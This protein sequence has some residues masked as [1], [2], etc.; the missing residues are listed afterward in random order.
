MKVC[1]GLQGSVDKASSELPM[2]QCCY[3][4]HSSSFAWKEHPGARIISNFIQSVIWL[5]SKGVAILQTNLWLACSLLGIEYIGKH[6]S[7]EDDFQIL[8]C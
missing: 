4:G 5:T 3:N 2:G 1:L 8:Q 7:H 6:I